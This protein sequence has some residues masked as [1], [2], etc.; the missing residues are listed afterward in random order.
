MVRSLWRRTLVTSLAWASLAWAQQ[1]PLP[2]GGSS[3]APRA[4]KPERIF[5]IQEAGKPSQ[6]CRV[7]KT[8]QTPEG[9]TAYQVQALDSGEVMTILEG[10]PSTTMPGSRPGT[11]VHAMATRIFH[12]GRDATP[13]DGTPMPPQFAEPPLSATPTRDVPRFSTPV[14]G[15]DTNPVATSGKSFGSS[16]SS[17]YAP[18]RAS[19]V[20]SSVMADSDQGGA[21]GKSASRLTT[22]VTPAAP[23]DWRSS[24]GKANDFRTGESVGRTPAARA[25]TTSREKP[26]PLPH[27]D[28]GRPDPL[29]APATYSVPV[30]EDKLSTRGPESSRQKIPLGAG[31][32]VSSSESF[33]GP[34]QYIPVP[35][36]TVPDAHPPFPPPANVPQAPQPILPRRDGTVGLFGARPNRALNPMPTTTDPGMVNAFTPL[37]SSEQVANAANAFYSADP[38]QGTPTPPAGAFAPGMTGGPAGMAGPGM[39]GQGYAAAAAYAYA[40]AAQA[41]QAQQV[42]G[43]L[44]DSLYPSQ[45]EWAADSLVGQDWRTNPEVL[46]GLLTAAREDPAPTVRAACVRCLAKMNANT[47]PVVGTIQALKSDADPRVRSEAEQ[48]LGT[49]TPGQASYGRP[50]VQPAGA[51][52]PGTTGFGN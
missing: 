16:G 29:Q 15:Q 36:V 33:S 20:S 37:P 26:Q 21:A 32:V 51:L 2:T 46:Q 4:E 44:R 14:R 1:P 45:R 12:W 52:M 10:G 39:A 25:E 42:L 8:W 11:R 34:V 31:S 47:V 13:P 43:V 50:S 17:P 3:A 27:A 22:T 19:T 23:T 18:G 24:W 7:L 38:R 28:T 41:A 49:L 40:G 5:T 48:A 6:K 9:V 35:I 30:T